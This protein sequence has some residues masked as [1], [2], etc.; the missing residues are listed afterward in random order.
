[1]NNYIFH[2][3]DDTAYTP[4]YCY[5]LFV[6]DIKVAKLLDQISI[7]FW[8]SQDDNN[9][10]EFEFSESETDVN[11]W[12]DKIKEKDLSKTDIEIIGEHTLGSELSDYVKKI[13]LKKPNGQKITFY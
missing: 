13:I 3:G 12:L 2:E 9:L 8:V 5:I 11:Y 1:M 7:D 4:G 10:C 6:C